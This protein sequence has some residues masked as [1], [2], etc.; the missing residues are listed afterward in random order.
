[1]SLRRSFAAAA[2]SLLTFGTVS[3]QAAER[4]AFVTIPLGTA[5]GLTEDNLSSYLVAP[6]GSGAFVALDAGTLNAG[7]RQ[8]AKCGALRGI[9]TAADA[10]E[11]PVGA[12]LQHH[13]MGYL[14]SHAHLDHVAGLVINSPEDAPKPIY[15]LA[16]TIDWLRD[17]LFNWQVWPAFGD[18][19]KG[20]L[21]KEYHYVRLTPGTPTALAGSTMTVEAYPLSHG[22]GYLSTAFLLQ[23]NGAAVLY[24]GDTG[25]DSL[26]KSTHIHEIWQRVA[27]LVRQKALRAVFLECSDPDGTPDKLL[28]GHLTPTLVMREMGDLAALV[29]PAHP[30]TALKGLTLVVTHIKPTYKAGPPMRRTIMQQLLAHNTLGLQ[31]VLPK[32]GR[33]LTF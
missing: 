30:E 1:M 4:P 2:M 8:A 16:T 13:V 31:L 10:G 11:T 14:I 26:E 17:H 20:F 12:M 22:S 19:G 15:G 28:F 24:F 6:T 21:L 7:L 23:A 29:D 32:Q 25:A 3:A 33:R 27:P 9:L 5:G 18:E